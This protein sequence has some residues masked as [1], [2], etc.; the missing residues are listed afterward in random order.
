MKP[1][2]EWI[3]G[4]LVIV[5]LVV[6]MLG[7][8]PTAYV[9]SMKLNAGIVKKQ[10]QAYSEEKQ[11][12]DRAKKVTYTLPRISSAEDEASLTQTRAPND[13]V[14]NFFVEQKRLRLAQVQEVTEAA[15]ELNRD[16]HRPLVDSFPPPP[17]ADRRT[18]VRAALD[19]GRA[20]TGERPYSQSA[21]AILFDRMGGGDPPSRDELARAIADLQER[22]LEAMRDAQSNSASRPSNEAAAQLQE[23][24][25]ERRLAEYRRRADQLCFFGSAN[26]LYG[27]EGSTAG[28]RSPSG[29]GGST[30]GAAT[31]FPSSMPSDPPSLSQAYLWQWDYWVVEDVLRAIVRANSD[32]TGDPL[33][34]PLGVVKRL[35]SIS[36]D[37]FV[38]PASESSGADAMDSMGF[39]STRM[40]GGGGT[41]APSERVTW[42]GRKQGDGPYDI[43]R[44]TITVVVSSSRLPAFLAAIRTT[45]LM[46]VTDLDITP[47]DVWADLSQGYF[48]GEEN[49]VRATISIESVWLREWT[50]DFMPEE[51]RNALGITIQNEAAGEG[52]LDG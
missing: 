2:L 11:K 36:I 8:L 26:I 4:H 38:I 27:G 21:Y 20:I 49:V 19:L 51:V 17:G 32:A 41:A 46:T 9:I 37:P 10:T 5:I 34:V 14:T 33:P 44:A 12:I 7:L 16:G 47:V 50:K 22:E 1:A 15:I 23:R 31:M 24:L 30:S 13:F 18:N 48:Y 40:A 45:N 39:G 3:K 6:L 29:R 52:G 28:V 42:T 43:R 35:E 25:V